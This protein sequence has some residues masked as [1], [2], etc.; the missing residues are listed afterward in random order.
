[1]VNIW[2]LSLF[3]KFFMGAGAP[4]KHNIAPLLRTDHI[5]PQYPCSP[6]LVYISILPS[7]GILS[8]EKETENIYYLVVLEFE[9]K[10][11]QRKK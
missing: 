3:F 2:L 11:L 9:S 8:I 7:L 5:S 4:T 6:F 10:K 1:M